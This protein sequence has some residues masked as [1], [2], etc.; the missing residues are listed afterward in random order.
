MPQLLSSALP[1]WLMV[2]ATLL[3]DI[4]PP[5]PL[6]LGELVVIGAI[7]CLLGLPTLGGVGLAI[8]LLKKKKRGEG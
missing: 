1:A 7:C 8:Y 3:L 2:G 6:G 4:A 5:P